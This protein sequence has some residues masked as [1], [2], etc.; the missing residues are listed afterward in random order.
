MTLVKKLS[1][2]VL[3]LKTILGDYL[4]NFNQYKFYL[5][6]TLTTDKFTS[7]TLPQLIIKDVMK[8]N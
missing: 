4:E 6:C 7:Q 2:F 3:T 8:I 1:Q 5:L